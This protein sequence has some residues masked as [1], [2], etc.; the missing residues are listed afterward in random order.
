[1]AGDAMDG[2]AEPADTPGEVVAQA[3]RDPGSSPEGGAEVGPEAHLTLAFWSRV[4]R[5]RD[6]GG[7]SVRLGPTEGPE[8]RATVARVLGV[9]ARYTGSWTV[10]LA[11]L[12]R[13]LAPRGGLDG[14]AGPVVDR[15]AARADHRDEREAAWAAALALVPPDLVGWAAQQRRRN[16]TRAAAQ[17][18]GQAGRVL[19][20]VPGPEGQRQRLAVVA[21]AAVGHPHALDPGRPLAALTLSGLAAR[22]GLPPPRDAAGR[23][24]LW[25]AS[26]VA[27]DDVSCDVLV[28]GLGCLPVPGAAALAAA[29]EPHRVTLRSLQRFGPPL[30][31]PTLV[32]VVENPSVVAAAADRLGPAC[33]PLVCAEGIPNSAVLLLLRS[34]AALGA[35]LAV[36]A[37]FDWGG[38]RIANALI[39]G[40]GAHPW[41]M[42]EADHHDALGRLEPADGAPPLTG[43]AVGATWDPGLRAA[44]EAAGTAIYEERVLEVLLTDLT[45]S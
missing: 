17:L 41:R 13:A 22:A 26:G 25:G 31:A 2:A 34:L 43:P 30:N 19:A 24:A 9:P 5:R 10:R 35:T 4:R 33:P 23:R 29:G 14:V 15:R 16:A 12:D 7:S 45:G 40:L 39:A 11:D 27:V 36:H 1:M 28:L 38:I 21:D 6:E 37:D 8:V 3:L 32:R 42:S 18:V 20:A 44:M